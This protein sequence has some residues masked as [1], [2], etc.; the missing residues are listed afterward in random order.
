[1]GFLGKYVAY[2][3]VTN[4]NG[5]GGGGILALL[6]FVVGMAAAVVWL[7]WRALVFVF[8]TIRSILLFSPLLTVST[9][10]MLIAWFTLSAIDRS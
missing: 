4:H 2:R 1:M 9:G 6:A 8:E 10:L 7:I 5:G 3:A